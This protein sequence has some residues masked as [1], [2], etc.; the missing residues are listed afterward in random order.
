MG[1]EADPLYPAS[2]KA[3]DIDVAGGGRPEQPLPYYNTSFSFNVNVAVAC[4]PVLASQLML[5]RHDRN[6]DMKINGQE[7]VGLV[8][9]INGTVWDQAYASHWVTQADLLY[10]NARNARPADAACPDTADDFAQG[11]DSLL[12]FAELAEV[13]PGFFQDE[14]RCV[15][16]TT[17]DLFGNPRDEYMC[18]PWDRCGTFPDPSRPASSGA[19]IEYNCGFGM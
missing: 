13:L 18:V 11:C 17:L 2:S 3:L 7:I 4:T 16:K 12:D 8:Q 6:E 10:F 19:T 1:Q 5:E 9:E 15:R 14:A